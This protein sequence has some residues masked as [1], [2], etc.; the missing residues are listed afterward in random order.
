MPQL[1][2]GRRI[3]ALITLALG[4]FAIGT[5]EFATMGILPLMAS[6][7]TDNF[8]TQPEQSIAAAGW[9]ITWY[10]VGVVVGAPVLAMATARFSQSKLAI[11]LLAALAFGNLLSAVAP[12]FFT[13]S[14]AR[15]IAGLPHGAYF[16]VASLLAARIM[17]PGKQGAGI[18][19]ALSGLT[20]ANVIGVPLGT[21]LGQLAGWRWTYAFVAVLFVLAMIMTIIAVPRFKGDPTRSALAELGAFRSARLWLVVAAGALSLAGFFTVYSY[22]AET[23]V[24]EAGLTAGFIPLALALVGVGMTLGN[25]AGGW[26]SDRAMERTAVAGV[27]AFVA[28]LLLFWATAANPVMLFAS[29]FLIGFTSSSFTPAIQSL[30]IR[31]AGRA[32]LLGASMNHSA[33]NIGNSIGAWLGGIVIAGGLGYLAPGLFGA[34]ASALGLVLLVIAFARIRRK[35]IDPITEELRIP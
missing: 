22:V 29:L 5:T 31:T 1:T 30:L 9:L 20:I 19:I 11:V 2:P 13:L 26:A 7:L 10:A 23:V 17:G 4:G 24:R 12:E 28:S 6:E 16:G 25:I 34:M 33:F 32:K 35:P 14:I 15:F 18:A 27:G 21:W 8:Q 3:L